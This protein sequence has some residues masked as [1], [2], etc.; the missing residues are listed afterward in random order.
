MT[1]KNRLV[2]VFLV[3]VLP[4]ALCTLATGQTA[5]LIG[6]EISVPQ[7]LQDGQEFHMSVPGLIDFGS[8]LFQ[9]RWTSQEGQGRPL[10]KGTGSPLTDPL[11]RLLFP[12][13]FDRLSGPD[14][15]SC[16]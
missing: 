11:S 2:R 12:R 7:H 4:L 9:A 8:S 10:T 14:A 16:F 13:N 15:N 5:S 6:R 1:R 3:S